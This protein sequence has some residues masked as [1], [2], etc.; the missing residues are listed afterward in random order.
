[1]K[2]RDEGTK[3]RRDGGEEWKTDQRKR[4][5]RPSGH[6]FSFFDKTTLQQEEDTA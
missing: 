3:G 4:V 5:P 6:V 1:M 2:K